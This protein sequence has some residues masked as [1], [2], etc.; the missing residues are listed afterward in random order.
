[1]VCAQTQ[2]ELGAHAELVA[3]KLA[4]LGKF[5]ARLDAA[6][7]RAAAARNEPPTQVRRRAH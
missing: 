7:A 2:S 5:T 6:A 4:A 1:M 3:Q